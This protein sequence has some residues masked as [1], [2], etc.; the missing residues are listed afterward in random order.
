MTAS[1]FPEDADGVGQV[2][3]VP[4]TMSQQDDTDL[5]RLMKGRRIFGEA[6]GADRSMEP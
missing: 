4:P 6:V 2:E 1:S 5:D 3:A